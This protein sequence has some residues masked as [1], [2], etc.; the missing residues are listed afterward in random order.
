MTSDQSKLEL[1]GTDKKGQPVH[2]IHLSGGGLKASILTWG[3]VLQD[4]RLD[5]HPPSLVLGFERFSDYLAH[6]PYF[7]TT[8]GRYA[9]RIANGRMTIDGKSYQLDLNEGGYGHLHGGGDGMGV[10]TWELV[11]YGS[12]YAVL[13]FTDPDG[14]GG[15]PGN[16]TA[17]TTYRLKEGGI[18][19]VTHETITDQPTPANICHHSYF[20]LDGGD[21]ILD[22]RIMIAAEHYLPVDDKLIPTGEQRS[23]EKTPFDFREIAPIRRGENGKQVPFDHN[24]C[25]SAERTEKRSIA[26]VE[27]LA[28]GVSLDV[29]STE[30][31]VQFYIGGSLDV[32]VPGLDGR[33]YQ[34]FGGFCLETQI[35]PDAVNHSNFP[36]AI[37]RPGDMLRQETDYI[38]AKA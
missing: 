13:T 29:R 4:L 17:T 25:L 36:K 31:G 26:R 14:R 22:H 9:N 11:D 24:F 3:G 21:T 32:P 27:S 16:C 33:H 38:F 10:N 20:N 8:P 15:Y 1:F 6:S 28:S 37:L 2:R 7:G 19:S 12:D 18:F 34:P 5:G 23:V 35:W 30:P